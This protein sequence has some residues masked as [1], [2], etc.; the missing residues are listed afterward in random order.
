MEEKYIIALGSI[1]GL[2]V[3]VTALGVYKIWQKVRSRNAIRLEQRQRRAQQR[4]GGPTNNNNPLKISAN[5]LL[6]E[7]PNSA[8]IPPTTTITTT[9][10][11]NNNNE[12]VKNISN[13]NKLLS[14][15]NPSPEVSGM[16]QTGTMTI[17]SKQGIKVR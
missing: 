4:S 14:S 12:S 5:K 15:V 11:N 10:N 3:I 17:S 9:N 13:S 6:L 2:L 1:F 7:T 16:S 8:S